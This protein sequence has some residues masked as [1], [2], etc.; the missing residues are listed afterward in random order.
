MPIF[1][2]IT[3]GDQYILE[4]LEDTTIVESK[5]SRFNPFKKPGHEIKV[6]VTFNIKLQKEDLMKELGFTL[7][8]ASEVSGGIKSEVFHKAKKIITESK[9]DEYKRGQIEFSFKESIK[10]NRT[11]DIPRDTKIELMFTSKEGNMSRTLGHATFDLF[12]LKEKIERGE[13]GEM[14]QAIQMNGTQLDIIGSARIKIL[15]PKFVKD[16]TFRERTGC[17]ILDENLQ[18]IAS[19]LLHYGENYDEIFRNRD[20]MLPTL[21]EIGF[22]IERGDGVTLPM[23][24]VFTDPERK[25]RNVDDEE[26]FIGNLLQ[27][28]LDRRG[29]PNEWF[30]KTINKKLMKGVFD[31]DVS[32]ACRI[33]G[34]V[35]TSTSVNRLQQT[36]NNET[37]LPTTESLIHI[38]ERFDEIEGRLSKSKDDVNSSQRDVFNIGRRIQEA[39][40]REPILN[41][42]KN[43]SNFY[44]FSGCL[45]SSNASLIGE[46]TSKPHLFTIGMSFPIF[47]KM[48]EKGPRP[49]DASRFL[50]WNLDEKYS[51]VGGVLPI[52]FLNPTEKVDPLQKNHSGGVNDA[53]KT[54]LLSFIDSHLP[55]ISSGYTEKGQRMGDHLTH[56]LELYTDS[57]NDKTGDC[58]VFSDGRVRGF[59][60]SSSTNPPALEMVK[61][62]S[63]R[64]SNVLRNLRNQLPNYPRQVVTRKFA[65]KIGETPMKINGGVLRFETLDNFNN[66]VKKIRGGLDVLP[67]GVGRF[68]VTYSFPG[69]TI[70]DNKSGEHSTINEILKEVKQTNS[71][72]GAQ[73]QM[74]YFTK[75][76]RCVDLRLT[77][78]EDSLPWER[79]RFHGG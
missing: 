63:V 8:I 62:E 20:C 23:K 73:L 45:G 12:L 43:L 15:N 19:S 9:L 11:M 40:F 13:E 49:S 34:D 61:R 10:I 4:D 41:D 50:K 60:L 64:D 48:V 56:L 14:A 66:E 28:S 77:F 59:G 38:P 7:R 71:I 75:H 16:L 69:D 30:T 51:N 42:L 76:N 74:N 26:R 55:T 46:Y 29:K 44:I 58:F 18:T 79:K 68:T 65:E 6:Q 39:T 3:T 32:D 25:T 53:K 33:L 35:L 17:E 5:F 21:E 78:D 70:F 72:I 54:K 1:K 67:Q 24:M 37:S 31:E 36:K 2:E 57:F 52:L 27:V 22:P 47:K